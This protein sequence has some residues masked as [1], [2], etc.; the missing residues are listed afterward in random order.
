M[1]DKKP[2]EM[3]AA[4]EEQG[5]WSQFAAA[6]EKKEKKSTIGSELV[7]GGKQL[8]SSIQTGAEA[9][10]GTPEEA[11]LAG[12]ERGRR[13]SEEAGEGVSLEAIK[14]AYEK[15][16]LLSAAGEVAGQIPRALAGQGAQLAA[17]AAAAKAGAMAGTPFGPAGT[18]IGGALGA[19]ASLLPQF[20][21]ANV[22]RQVQEQIEA[23]QAPKVDLGRAGAAAA[24]QAAIEGAGTAFVL[25]KRVV[26]G[27][28]GIADDAALATAKAQQEMVK[29]AERTMLQA[30]GRG[31][32]RG[33]TEIPVEVAQQVLERAQAGLDVT[34]PE[35]LSEYGEAAYQAV[36]VGGPL[37]SVSGPIDTGMARQARAQIQQAE[38]EQE[39]RRVAQ[40]QQAEQQR[41]A[42]ERAAKEAK[43]PLMLGVS[44]PFA[45]VV[46]PDGSVATTP[47]DVVRYEEEQFRKKYQ[48]QPVEQPE[49][50]GASITQTDR[51]ALLEGE[52]PLAAAMRARREEQEAK[53]EIPASGPWE[54]LFL[55]RERL[56]SEPKTKERDSMISRLDDEIMRLGVQ[57]IEQARKDREMSAQSAFGG[58]E[59]PSPITREQLMAPKVEPFKPATTVP[60]SSLLGAAPAGGGVADLLTARREAEAA[61]AEVPLSEDYAFLTREKAR[62][63]ELPKTPEN[64]AAIGRID[65][66]IRRLDVQAIERRRRD[67]EAAKTS[68]FAQ[69]QLPPVESRGAVVA[70]R[71]LAEMQAR[72]PFPEPKKS[73]IRKQIEQAERLA[74]TPEPITDVEMDLKKEEESLKGLKAKNRGRPLIKAIAGLLDPKEIPNIGID[75]KRLKG[76]LMNKV[77]KGTF[78]S[79]LVSNGSLDEFLEPSQRLD[80]PSRDVDKAT[81]TIR[82]K[83]EDGDYSFYGIGSEIKKAEAKIDYLARLIGEPK[84]AEF[85]ISE[86]EPGEAASIERTAGDA[87]V[88]ELMPEVEGL[89]YQRATTEGRSI[90]KEQ[91][92]SVVDAITSRWDNAPEVVVAEN[93]D[94]PAIPAEVRAHNKA[95]MQKG[96]KGSPRGFFYKG[97]AYVLADAATSPTQVMETLF[98]ES[99]GHY[100]LRG[101]FGPEME[102]VLRDV[103][104]NRRADVEAKAEQYGLD[105]KSESDMLEAA[106]EVL[107]EI[108]Q[109]KPGLSFVK[110]AIAVIR[111]FLR[112][113]GL[114][115]DMSNDDIIQ[116]YIL[117]ARAFVEKGGSKAVEGKPAAMREGRVPQTETEAFKRWFGDSKVVDENGKPRVM[118]HGTARDFSIF[119]RL[120]STEFR[121]PSMDTVGSWFSSD[122]NKAA[123]YSGGEGLN[124][125][126]VYLSIKNPK[127]YRSFDDFLRDMHEAEGRKFEEQQP[128]GIGS[129]EGLR[130]KLKAEGYDGI[131][132]EQTDN[133]SLYQ[134]IKQIQESI[135]RARDEEFSV[136]RADRAPY[137]MKRERLENTLRSMKAELDQMGGSTEFDG[138]DVFVAL[139]PNQIK[140]ATGNIGTF[141]PETADIRYQR[142]AEPE[143]RVKEPKRNILGN[144]VLGSWT[145]PTD[146]KLAGTEFGKDDLIYSL[147]DK[148]VDIKRVVQNITETA[149]RIAAKW[150][151]YLQEELYHGRTARSTKEFLQDELRPLIK[152]IQRNGMTIEEVEKYLHNRH[153][154][155]YNKHVAKVNPRNPKMQDGGSGIKT[156]DARAYLASIP[157]DKRKVYEEIAKKVDA[158]TKKTRNLVVESGL[159]GPDTIAAWEEA[160]PKYVPLMREESDDFDYTTPAFG[161][162]SGFDVRGKFSRAAMGSE[163]KVANILANI[164]MQREKAIIKSNK[165]RVAQAVFGL[166]VQNPNPDFWLAVNP[167]A[168]TVPE[169]ALDELRAMGIDEGAIEFLMQEP[170]Q[171]AIDPKKNE[172]VNRINATLR[173]SD[174]VLAMRI[175]GEDRY[176]FFNQNDPRAKRAAEAL[177]NLDADQLGPVLGIV[178]KITRW[179]A[180]FNTQYNPIFGA[181]NF[182]R[183]VQG[184]ALQLSDTPLR[185]KQKEVLSG[186]LPSL[187]TIY[188]AMRAERDGKKIDTEMG[189]LWNEFQEEGGQTGFRDMFSRSQE[190]ADALEKEFKQIT[191]GK[192]KAA[193]RAV[194]DWLSDYN[195]SMENA[196]RLSAYKVAKEKFIKDGMSES[197]AKQQAASIA[198]NLT[199][200]FNRKGQIATQAGALYAFFNAA[201]QGTTRLAQTLRGPAGRK[202]I[203]GGLL[204]GAMQAALLAAAGFDEEEPPEFVRERNIIIPL[205]GDKY[206]AF[207]MPLGYHVIPGFSRIITEWAL[208][209]FKDTPE[210]IASL[211]GM[212]LE[213]FNPI[214]NAGW[215]VQTLAPTFADPLVALSENKDWTGKPIARKD[216]SNMDPT[217][218][219]TRAKDT[220]SEFSTQIAKFLNYASGGTEFRPG[221]LSPT[222]DQ[223]DYLIGQAFGGLGREATKLEQTVLKTATGEELPPYKIPLVGRFYGETKS[224]AAESNRFYKNLTLLNEHENEIKGRRDK[225]QPI[226]DY[227]KDN[228]EARLAPMARKTYKDIQQL[229]KRREQLVE[230]DAPRE[231]VKAVEEQ[232]KRRMSVFNE[233]VA[234]LKD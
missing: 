17:M 220:A 56:R 188:A 157:A 114:P 62:L 48:P 96:A 121:R 84:R 230:R 40:E 185:G 27:V 193:G 79:E 171:R 89:R 66:E 212:F 108:A 129:A 60:R 160:F 86:V 54:F 195:D 21:G 76:E 78:L 41:L 141:S 100:G 132:F 175:N 6:P 158:I 133:E 131:Q 127:L 93:M 71:D 233:R 205:G 1:A 107:A 191:E 125:M 189:R 110:R 146:T 94:D 135:K 136:K 170:K 159:E 120:K 115:F 45:P 231:S 24:G 126:P 65:E 186:V 99:L 11:A 16:G 140:S 10:F 20:L 201:V 196:T 85:E 67:A 55:Q 217:P 207:P 80:S 194:F 36:L 97:K 178:S 232:I 223:I 58:E 215:S 202:I 23:G 30:A 105:P 2:W 13:I 216:F 53:A 112:K 173:K 184:A 116:K 130:A 19:G 219:Y 77:G 103:V 75:D 152:E 224:S 234:Q 25:G 225:G 8:A 181:Y 228:P 174:N 161:V 15:E 197:E 70:E 150:N 90:G 87:E 102:S 211:T 74:G 167:A 144:P 210:R 63:S 142:E 5:P 153:A 7:R 42:A 12:L 229:R 47:E 118:Y 33:A 218:G 166:A 111:N 123:Q 88:L 73:E 39:K 14:R 52:D 192:V 113:L 168:E 57:T 145:T 148:Q 95:A 31:A 28:L 26:K 209:G 122:P 22:E 206:F 35:A 83:I 169:I 198:K 32:A 4:P 51:A 134:E 180:S 138:H 72:E 50:I 106:E 222:P 44:E 59:L 61:Q 227:L 204:L 49:P 183:D 124:V 64:T 162:G 199:V 68:V 165:N 3:F 29:A 200:N 109:T 182:L 187:K 226:G 128:K 9:L 208:S 69:E 43:P 213:A 46:F 117:P 139:D 143:E 137:T 177:K 92:Q 147:Q 221:V 156:E 164:A 34:S 214:G 172:V 91:T 190:R 151:P 176:V 203:A 163:R 149:G 38:A 82:E 179:M 81:Q 119:D 104:K 98:H 101:T 37:G 154:E 18:V 155:D